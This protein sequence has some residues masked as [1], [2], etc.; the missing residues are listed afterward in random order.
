MVHELAVSAGAKVEF[1][2]TVEKVT[3]GERPSVTLEGGRV[4]EADIVIGA[5]GPRSMV[6]DVVLGGKVPLE[7][8]GMTAFGATLPISA[9]RNDPE[10]SQ[11]L[12]EGA[13]RIASLI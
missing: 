2:A 4:I 3:P 11:M 12:K 9:M 1:G 6:R 8:D 13:V 10:L 5:D 7:Y